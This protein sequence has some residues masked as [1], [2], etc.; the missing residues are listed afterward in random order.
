[1]YVYVLLLQVVKVNQGCKCSEKREGFL[2][3][4]Y[5]CA[6]SDIVF[7]RCIRATMERK[8]NCFN[9]SDASVMEFFVSWLAASGECRRYRKTRNNLLTQQ[10]S[11]ALKQI[12]WTSN[13]RHENI[14]FHRVP[15]TSGPF[16]NWMTKLWA[17]LAGQVALSVVG[18]NPLHQ[19]QVGTTFYSSLVFVCAAWAVSFCTP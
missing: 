12:L 17:S 3:N 7:T 5:V 4:W 15:R 6:A 19:Q 9:K 13:R 11:V 16:L 2:S 14:P 18:V 8:R 10:C 1:M